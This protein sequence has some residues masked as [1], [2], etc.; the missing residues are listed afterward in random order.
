MCSTR[1]VGGPDGAALAGA[2][3]SGYA[4]RRAEVA[5]LA[6]AE[7]SKSSARKGVGVRLPSSAVS[8]INAFRRVAYVPVLV[9]EEP[10]AR[11]V[12]NQELTRS[13]R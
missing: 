4:A 11:A 8:W 2:A 12:S 1:L 7:D 9:H 13:R 6:D 3:R 5:E 10:E